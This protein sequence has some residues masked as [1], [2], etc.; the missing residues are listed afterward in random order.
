[1]TVLVDL[2]RPARC[3]APLVYRRLEAPTA[4]VVDVPRARRHLRLDEDDDGED[5]DIEAAIDAATAHVDGRTGVLN[6]ALVSQV[7]LA[8]A[9]RPMAAA[10]GLPGFVLDL[11]P[12]QAVTTVEVL[13]GGVYAVLPTSA[14]R[15]VAMTA[16]RVAVVPARGAAWPA[17]DFDPEAWRIT[18]RAGYGDA[19]EA[20]PSPIRS[21]ILLLVADLF[22]QRDGKVQAN[23]VDNPTVDRL[24]APFRR[25]AV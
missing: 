3:E 20:V 17:Y 15:T 14:W 4:A 21:A 9:P 23:L 2:H 10:G 24:L 12:I 13:Q 8:T 1:M 18:F 7:W 11:V 19:G 16:D 6:R 25:V 22:D 5:L